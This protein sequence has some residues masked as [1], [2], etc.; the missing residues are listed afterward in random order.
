MCTGIPPQMTAGTSPAAKPLIPRVKYW[1]ELYKTYGQATE[2]SVD[3]LHY[4][5]IFLIG[6]SGGT[7]PG[8]HRGLFAGSS[9]PVAFPPTLADNATVLVFCGYQV[10]S[11]NISFGAA[12]HSTFTL[13]GASAAT[14]HM[15]GGF[16]ELSSQQVTETIIGADGATK[17]AKKLF[18]SLQSGQ[19]A[20]TV[21]LETG[22]YARY[23][24][25]SARG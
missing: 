7:E 20:H 13:F 17:A 9:L 6:M 10:P 24:K 16:W 4:D 18:P 15:S 1:L 14:V 5:D 2:S 23:E 3:I 12:N 8:D 22:E 19:K 11:T 25:T 21:A